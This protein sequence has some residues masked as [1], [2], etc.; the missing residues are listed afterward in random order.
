MVMAKYIVETFEVEVIEVFDYWVN[1]SDE[2]IG[3]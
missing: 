1:I 3:E 2:I